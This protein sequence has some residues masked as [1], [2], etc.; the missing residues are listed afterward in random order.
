MKFEVNS[1]FSYRT[2]VLAAVSEGNRPNA[3]IEFIEHEP[4]HKMRSFVRT[5][6]DFANEICFLCVGYIE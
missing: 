3:K 1:R 5:V 4:E 2:A 6:E